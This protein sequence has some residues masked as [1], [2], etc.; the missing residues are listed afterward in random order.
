MGVLA[1]ATPETAL[2]H[3]ACSSTAGAA[4]AAGTLVLAEAEAG[5]SLRTAAFFAGGAFTAAAASL[6]KGAG[7]EAWN[8]AAASSPSRAACFAS[9]MSALRSAYQE[10][11]HV[12]MQ[13]EESKKK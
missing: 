7:S 12:D 2:K 6:C 10:S 3:P 9:S 1:L 11:V 8:K 13:E 4:G 5:V